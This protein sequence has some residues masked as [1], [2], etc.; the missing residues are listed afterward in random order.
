[1]WKELIDRLGKGCK[2]LDP[3]NFDAIRQAEGKLS[4]IFPADLRYLLLE[5]NGIGG[6]GGNGLI[7]NLDRIVKD[8][9]EFRSYPDF[10]TLYMPF[11]HL[12]F[13]G[14]DGSGDQFAFRILAGTVN[15]QG[16]F[17]WCHE[18]DAREWFAGGMGDYL[19]RAL[20]HDSFFSTLR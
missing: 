11:D 17:R 18:N 2:F 15:E 10:R 4:I 7:W 9:S 14:D 3:T 20:G 8:N 16:V 12:L 6:P 1:M 19:A 5:A 13:F